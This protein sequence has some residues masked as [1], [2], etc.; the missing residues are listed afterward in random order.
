MPSLMHTIDH[1]FTA[2]MHLRAQL[3]GKRFGLV[4]C[5]A[6]QS[7]TCDSGQDSGLHTF[8]G[9][10]LPLRRAPWQDPISTL[11]PPQS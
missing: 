4:T 9:H 10:H 5:A 3:S 2:T 1:E 11:Q 7:Q 8:V 6:D